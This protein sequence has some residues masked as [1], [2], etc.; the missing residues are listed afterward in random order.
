MN[1]LAGKIAISNA[2]KP[3]AANI[4][5][6]GIVRSMPNSISAIPLMVLINLGFLNTGGMIL[7]YIPGFLK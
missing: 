1:K 2:I 6:K 4:E 3:Q 5:V 7:I